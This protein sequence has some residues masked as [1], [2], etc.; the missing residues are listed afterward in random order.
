M[1]RSIF[2]TAS[3][4][5]LLIGTSMIGSTFAQRPVPAAPA[6]AA[7]TPNLAVPADPNAAVTATAVELTPE[8]EAAIYREATMTRAERDQVV[9]KLGDVIPATV[10][11][12]TLPDMGI[13]KVRGF[14][15]LVVHN[16]RD[17]LSHSVVLVIDPA[18]R[19]VARIIQK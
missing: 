12:S 16:L 10:A 18:T 19:K 6:P 15:Y 14:Q 17:G 5:A 13:D 1:K 11:L 2:T 4:V 7:A 8:Q 9:I 3:I